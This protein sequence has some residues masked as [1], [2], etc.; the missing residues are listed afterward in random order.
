MPETMIKKGKAKRVF[1]RDDTLLLSAAKLIGCRV[2]RF[3]AWRVLDD[4]SLVVIDYDGK[5]YHFSASELEG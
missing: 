3:I 2:E 1:D 4:G 5:K